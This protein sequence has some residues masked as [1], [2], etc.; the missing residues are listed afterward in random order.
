MKKIDWEIFFGDSS[1]EEALCLFAG[2]HL[3]FKEFL[4]AC[5][6]SRERKQVIR[7]LKTRGYKKSIRK[8]QKVLIKNGFY[9]YKDVYYK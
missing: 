5:S 7:R 3:S 8:A 1:S 6:Y 4:K 9:D 2:H